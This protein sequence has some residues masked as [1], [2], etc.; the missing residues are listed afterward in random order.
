MLAEAESARRP[1]GRVLLALLLAAVAFA[2]VIALTGAGGLLAHAVAGLLLLL[3]GLSA[4]LL[5]ARFRPVDPRPYPRT[6][7]AVAALIAMGIAGATLGALGA[8][9]AF[10]LLPLLPWAVL[11][12]AT[13]DAYR[14]VLAAP[15]GT[16]NARA[17]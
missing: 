12:G 2:A 17:I 5:A 14:C 16:R 9:P 1:L 10:E 8:P 13:G 11:V 3:L 6:L 15:A 4:V 7:L